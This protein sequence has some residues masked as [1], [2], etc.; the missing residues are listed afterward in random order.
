[1]VADAVAVAI[2]TQMGDD[3][4]TKVEEMTRR[5]KAED[6]ALRGELIPEKTT[7]SRALL[8][9]VRLQ[10]NMKKEVKEKENTARLLNAEQAEQENHAVVKKP[11]ERRR[12][13]D[14][15]GRGT[16]RYSIGDDKAESK[17]V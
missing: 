6:L 9:H 3:G 14:N 16:N 7:F 10:Q 4:M 11:Q 8:D 12:N 13:C 17:E 2:L 1:M 5:L 15:E